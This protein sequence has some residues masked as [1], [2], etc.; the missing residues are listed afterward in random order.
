MRLPLLLFL[1]ATAHAGADVVDFELRTRM[2]ADIGTMAYVIRKEQGNVIVTHT[3]TETNF[4]DLV[5]DADYDWVDPTAATSCD[6]FDVTATS[7]FSGTTWYSSLDADQ[8]LAL[9]RFFRIHQDA[10]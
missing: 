3:L 8:K 5:Q 1:S 9:C 10:D 7:V 4:R 2:C 6:G